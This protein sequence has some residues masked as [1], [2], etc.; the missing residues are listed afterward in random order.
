MNADVDDVDE[1]RMLEPRHQA[2]LVD[3][4]ALRLF[5]EVPGEDLE[6]H[7][8]AKR[9][10][11]RSKDDPHSSLTEKPGHLVLTD[12]LTDQLK[13]LLGVLHAASLA[14]AQCPR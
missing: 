14:A 1:A 10:L 11:A 5:V 8:T 13:E 7:V 12:G 9:Q 3:E 6:R 2:S 4:A